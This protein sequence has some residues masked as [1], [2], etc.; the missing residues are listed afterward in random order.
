VEQEEYRQ[1]EK[2]Y[3]I[4][5]ESVI[6]AAIPPPVKKEGCVVSTDS[7]SEHESQRID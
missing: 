3:G 2:Q 6:P 4:K 7:E 5:A 1:R